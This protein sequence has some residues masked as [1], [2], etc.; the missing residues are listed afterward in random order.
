MLSRDHSFP[1]EV[2]CIMCHWPWRNYTFVKT[3]GP[4]PNLLLTCI[5]TS[6]V[7]FPFSA[8]SSFLFSCLFRLKSYSIYPERVFILYD[9]DWYNYNTFSKSN[10]FSYWS[11]IPQQAF[12]IISVSKDVIFLYWKFISFV[13]VKDSTLLAR[14][15]VHITLFF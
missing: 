5:N 10:L 15:I 12:C 4:K 1:W 11:N 13:H 2:R 6:D 3:L 14:K 8:S 9:N 7:I